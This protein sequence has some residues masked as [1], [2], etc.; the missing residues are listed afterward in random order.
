M[1]IDQKIDFALDDE[2]AQGELQFDPH[3][4][5]V[6]RPVIRKPNDQ[7]ARLEAVVNYNC[8]TNWVLKLHET[9]DES[10]ER[11]YKISSY[12]LVFFQYTKNKSLLSANPQN[13]NIILKEPK[14]K[15][16]PEYYL[17]S[18]WEV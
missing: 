4:Y 17:D 18:I 1:F 13:A 8:N 5:E 16:Q 11:Q 14:N 15:A 2:M 10:K 12:D 9:Y 7:N 6:F 3:A